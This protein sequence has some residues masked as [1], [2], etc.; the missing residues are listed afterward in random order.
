VSINGFIE[1][2]ANN[3][4]MSMS[5]GYEVEF[6]LGSTGEL[7]GLIK[8]VAGNI[9]TDSPGDRGFLVKYLCDE[10]QLPNVQA[11]TGQINGRHL[12]EGQINYAHTKLY[13]DFSLSWM[14][15][16][17]MT[18]LKFLTT[19]HSFIFNGGDADVPVIDLAGNRFETFKDSAKSRP[20]RPFNRSIRLKFPNQYM[21]KA[22]ICKTERGK[23]AANSR[24]S[25]IY[26]MED[27]YPYAVDAVP[28]SYGAS[29]VTK[30]TANFYYAKH[31]VFFNDI[32]KYG[33]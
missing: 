8:G 27:C 13:S 17:N 30:V 24:S 10:A 25:V 1:A 4:G 31:N 18:P 21:A 28:L 6:D 33:G 3:G 12:G 15:D 2:I 7:A 29:Q 22:K 14:C 23:N 9:N 5:N 11:M 16:A 32:S 20:D 19:W 26:L